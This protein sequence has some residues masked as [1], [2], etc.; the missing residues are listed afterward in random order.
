MIHRTPH[1]TQV[2]RVSLHYVSTVHY[3]VH[4]VIN[5]TGISASVTAIALCVVISN[6]PTHTDLH[7]YLPVVIMSVDTSSVVKRAIPTYGVVSDDANSLL[8]TLSLEFVKMLYDQA[9]AK[10]TLDNRDFVTGDDVVW[11]CRSFGLEG[12][13]EAL[14]AYLEKYRESLGAPAQSV[15]VKESKNL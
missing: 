2:T 14:G 13:S 10:A 11:A 4:G 5:S 6:F 3:L 8:S 1:S 7:H 15:E 9:D 12:Y